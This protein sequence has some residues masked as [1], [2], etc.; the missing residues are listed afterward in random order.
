V[1]AD[2]K[3]RSSPILLCLVLALAWQSPALA[4]DIDLFVGTTASAAGLPNVLFVVDNTANWNTAFTNEMSALASVFNNLPN[5]KFNI[6]IEF[7]TETGGGNSNTPGGYV[8]AAIRPMTSSNKAVYAALIQSLNKLSDKGNGG[9]SAMEMAEAYYYFTGGTPYAG[10]NK[11]KTDY[12]GNVSGG[13]SQSNAIYAITGNALASKA[14]TTYVAPPHSGCTSYFIIYISNGPNQENASADSNA[15]TKLS[16]VG[17]DTTQ[18]P[19]YPT[20]S[21]SNPSDEWARFMH[22]SP[23]GV[24]TYTIDVDPPTTG[25]GPGWTALLKSMASVSQGQYAAVSSSS[26]SQL[27][28]TINN[29]LSQIQAIN[30][31]FASV[32]L[33]L[34][35]NMQGTYLDQVYIGMFRPDSNAEPRWEGNLKQYKLGLISSS[36]LLEDA[37]GTSAVNSLTGFVTECARSYWTPKT[38]DAYWTFRPQGNCIPPVGSAPDFYQNSNYPDGNVVEKGAEAYIRRGS[39]SRVLKTCSPVFASCTT[40]TDFNTSNA[41]ITT[42]LL[43]AQNNPERNQLINWEYGLDVDDENSN[44]VT[45][46]EMRPSVHGDVV[47]SRPVAINF[48]TSSQPKVVVL[49]GGNDGVLRAINGNREDS[50]GANDFSGVQ[51][52]GEL[53]AF[54]PPEFWASPSPSVPSNVKRLRDDN[55]LISFPNVPASA[56]PLP[57]PYGIDGVISAYT[58][59]S[60]AWIYAP[61]RRGGRVLY[62]FAIDQT[63]PANITFNWKIGCPDPTDDVGCSSSMSGI[64]ETWSA[65]KPFKA[66]GYSSGT[67]PLLI[68][69]GGYDPCEDASPNTCTTSNKGNVVYVVRADTGAPVA[70]FATDRGVAADVVIVPDANGLALFAYVADLGGNIYRIDIGSAGAASWPITKIASLGCDTPAVCTNNRKF[71]FSPDVVLS[72]G[73]YT[74]LLGSGDREK[75]RNYSDP[76]NN[77]F[78]MVQD[79]PTDPTWESSESGRCGAAVLCLSSL[80]QVTTSS[81]PLPSDLASH[82]GWYLTLN[83]TEQVVTSALTIYGNVTFST[84]QPI[85]PAAGVCT[86][87]LGIARVYNVSF[88]NGNGRSD[89]LPNNVGLPPSPVGGMVT[90]DSGQTVPFCIG[91]SPQSPIQSSEPPVPAGTAL[92]QPKSR[93]YWYIQR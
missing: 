83:A 30:S 91:C 24:V 54:I 86:S 76:V 78:F 50:T 6:G 82:K 15:N 70:S 89:V 33:P 88:A 7:A 23:L 22:S 13:T 2:M 26:S 25:Q 68:F 77:Y 9:Y 67:V 39:T 73:V 19:I 5:N 42:A 44:N 17:G 32:S 61:M 48:G 58:D 3:T 36:L 79:K 62:S 37:D 35:N 57:K 18:I 87:N 65:A 28:L 51:P 47:H 40:L 56:N 46:T 71:M 60:N 74:L 75:P 12:I 63:N 66:Q 69:G 8:R 52:G 81:N 49:Y 59:S 21:A 84:H 31:V 93:V 11:V 90:L 43:G 10:N 20:G 92:S 16:A 1:E 41:A 29:V 80:L 45:T 38:A 85:L 53:W 64:G 72:N 4:E 34:S 14:A 27:A 55:V